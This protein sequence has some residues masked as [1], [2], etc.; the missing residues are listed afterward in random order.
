MFIKNYEIRMGEGR[1]AAVSFG[2]GSEN[3][4]IIPGLEDGVS[5]VRGKA[6]AGLAV[7]APYARKFRVTLISRDDC[8]KSGCTTA[9]MAR[10]LAHCMQALAI[11]KAHVMGVS[12]GGM[13]AQH[14]AADHPEMVG[15]LVLTSTAPDCSELARENIQRWIS[16]ARMGSYLGLIMDTTEKAHPEKYLKRL[17]PLYPY[18]APRFKK[19]NTE[20]FAAMA[21]ACLTHDTED[22]LDRIQSPTLIICGGEDRILG[23]DGSHKLHRYIEDSILK[24]YP[25]QGH[26]L[27]EDE[28]D[29]KKAVLNFLCDEKN[30]SQ[31]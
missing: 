9:D 3:L 12:Q 28:P 8:L 25:E 13:I 24:I 30:L 6:L 22:K 1:F 15:K 5:S 21:E 2:S 27:Y 11:E 17:R 23:V 18:L 7:F 20:R 19:M 26:A 10:D 16:F 31:D 29:Y 14:L 4:V